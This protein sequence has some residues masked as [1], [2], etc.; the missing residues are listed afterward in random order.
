MKKIL[1]ALAL[2]S[3]GG[4]VFYA[5][6]SHDEQHI[7]EE[8]KEKLDKIIELAHTDIFHSNDDEKNVE[9]E[10]FTK[11]E[12]K[13]INNHFEKV[14]NDWKETM[15]SF[16]VRELGM[17]QEVV[18]EYESLK[19][20]YEV[21]LSETFEEFHKNM[22]KKHGREYSYSPSKVQEELT[23]KIAQ[24]YLL[25]IKAIFGHDGFIKYLERKDQFNEKLKRESNPEY[26]QLIMEL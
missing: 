19:N 11:D 6:N 15:S 18:S 13:S 10:V 4:I 12:I 22:E 26:G 1:I 23:E 5:L 14:Q 7:S 17:S 9:D 21:E 8:D 24:K 2:F 3:L 20:E 25:K 16:V